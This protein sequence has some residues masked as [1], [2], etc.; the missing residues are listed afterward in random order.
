MS[1]LFLDNCSPAGCHKGACRFVNDACTCDCEAG[2]TGTHCDT[3]I[4]AYLHAYMSTEGTN[5]VKHKNIG[6]N[7]FNLHTLFFC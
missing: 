6:A 5:Y 2:Y 4:G 7:V 1:V 3:G